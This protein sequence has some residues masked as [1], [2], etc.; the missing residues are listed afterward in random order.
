MSFSTQVKQELCALPV[1]SSCCAH[2]LCYGLLLFGKSFSARAVSFSTEEEPLAQYYREMLQEN[3]ALCPEVNKS[4]VRRYT[5]SIN[6]VA[7]CLRILE[8]FGHGGREP[9]LR[10]NRANFVDTC[11]Q[12][13]FLRGVFLSCGTVSDPEKQYHL[14]FVSPYKRLCSDFIALMQ[15]MELRP[16]YINRK[17]NHVVYVKDSNEIEDVL[18]VMGATDASLEL[19]GVKIHKDMRNLV[20]RK[21]NFETANIERT[22]VAAMQQ[23]RAIAALE[24][25]GK[26]ETLPEGLRELALLR[27]ENPE[28]S[29]QELSDM[30]AQ[31]LTRSGVKHRLNRL[32]QLAEEMVE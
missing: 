20:N 2:A 1:L 14:E 15:E 27:R 28:A 9:S 7:D 6:S 32:I 22:V 8:H 13:A 21:L 26:L 25:A 30:L 12:H 10:I 17:G 16:K 19:M 23:T 4:G 18:T 5:T 11:C 29:L 3:C 24:R 31:P